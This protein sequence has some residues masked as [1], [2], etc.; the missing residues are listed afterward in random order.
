MHNWPTLTWTPS[1]RANQISVIGC[2]HHPRSKLTFSLTKVSLAFAENINYTLSTNIFI[3]L[4]YNLRFFYYF[5]VT[6]AISQRVA[7]TAAQAIFQ[8]IGSWIN[9]SPGTLCLSAIDTRQTKVLKFLDSQT[10]RFLKSADYYLKCSKEINSNEF[11]KNI[12]TDDG[13]GLGNCWNCFR[14]NKQKFEI[15][16]KN[17]MINIKWIKYSIS[18]NIYEWKQFVWKRKWQI[19]RWTKKYFKSLSS[20]YT[21]IEIAWFDLLICFSKGIQRAASKPHSDFGC[22]Q[23]LS[24]QLQLATNLPIF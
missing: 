4:S 11:R 17:W 15:R 2:E 23:K 21:L 18:I 5:A 16:L 1:S 3:C 14:V 22:W 13:S 19:I 12:K 24:S 9:L 10:S 8:Q 20:H 7:K 6:T